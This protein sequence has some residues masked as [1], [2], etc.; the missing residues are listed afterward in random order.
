VNAQV[1]SARISILDAESQEQIQRNLLAQIL[2]ATPEQYNIQYNLDTT[3]Y[4]KQIPATFSDTFDV[5]QNPQV[6][7]FQSR[8]TQSDKYADYLQ[9]SILPGLNLFG[10]L[11]SRGSGFSSNYSPD[12]NERYSKKLWDGINPTRT[13]YVAGVSIAWNIISPAKIRHQVA[14]QRFISKGYAAET[15]LI[16]TQ[17]KA[18]LALA[19]QRIAITLQRFRE[20]PLQYKAASDAFIQKSVLYKN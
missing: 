10:I 7:Y 14:A 11:Q 12:Y 6:K 16:S 17:L 13:N 19:D 4:F 9:K 2:N 18:R 1:S 15:D 5:A 8:V 3:F 20:V